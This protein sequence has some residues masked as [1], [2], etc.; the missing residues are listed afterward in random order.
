MKSF[1]NHLAETSKPIFL[2]GTGNGADKIIAVLEQYGI[3]LTGV[4]ASDGF[5]RERTFHGMKVCSYSNVTER[6]GDEIIVLLAFG[7]TLP[8]VT[9]FIEEL[10]RRHELYV[11]DVPLYGGPLFNEEYYESYRGS[12]E[13]L[14]SILAD[15]ESKALLRDCIEFRLH[16]KLASLSRTEDGAVTL[17]NLLGHKKYTTALDGGAFKGDS[18]R[19]FASSLDVNSI[20]AVEADPKTHNKLSTYASEEKNAVV[21]AIHGALWDEDGNLPY[22]SSASRGSSNEGQNHRAKITSVPACKIDTLFADVKADFIKLDIEGAEEQALKGG[23]EVLLRDKPDLMIS[24]YHRTDDLFRLPLWIHQLLPEHKLY[25][26][27]IPC[28]PLWDLSLYA[29][30]D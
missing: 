14:E 28:I 15:E 29:V 30:K 9:A 10:D 6:Y 20:W 24:L 11:P 26:R 21:K 4:F 27:R 12:L 8:T 7:T 22:V 17:K 2:Y 5:V 19:L 1:W 23:T 13:A 18:T 3:P 16:G 25:L